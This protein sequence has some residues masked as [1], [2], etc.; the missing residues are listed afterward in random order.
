MIVIAFA[1]DIGVAVMTI[2]H[3][4]EIF[5]IKAIWKIRSSLE[6]VGIALVEHKKEEVV[7]TKRN[8]N[9]SY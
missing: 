9:P 1:G 3:R 2:E 4:N 8:R 5:A 6:T 7:I